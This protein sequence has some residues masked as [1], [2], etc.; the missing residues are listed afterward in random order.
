MYLFDLF[1]NIFKK[2]NFGVLI[3]LIINTVLVTFCFAVIIDIATGSV[4]EDWLEYLLGFAAYLLTV[5]VALSPIGEAILRFQTG[6]KKIKDE[7]TLE[8]LEKLFGEVREKSAYIDST[9]NRNIKMFICDDEYPNAFATGR[10]TVCVTAGLLKLTDDEIKGVLA[11]EFG[12]LSHKDTDVILVIAVGNMFVTLAV[13]T[14]G[15]IVR[16]F[17]WIIGLFISMISSSESSGFFIGFLTSKF[18]RLVSLL[19]GAI[20]WLWTKLGVVICMTSSRQNEYYAD[21]FAFETGF[22]EE[23]K[24][25][26][27]NLE[28]GDIKINRKQT[29]W[30]SLNASHPDTCLR[31]EKLESYTAGGCNALERKL[32]GFSKKEEKPTSEAKS[33]ANSSATGLRSFCV[34]ISE[35][36]F[37]KTTYIPRSTYEETRIENT[38]H[39]SSPESVEKENLSMKFHKAN[40]FFLIPVLIISSITDLATR[41]FSIAEYGL[42]VLSILGV[43]FSAAQILVS[44]NTLVDFKNRKVSAFYSLI[45]SRII[46]VLTTCLSLPELYNGLLYEGFDVG[47]TVVVCMLTFAATAGFAV[48]V[49]VYYSKRK[50][51]LF[52]SAT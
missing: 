29:L 34:G 37:F 2:K 40:I 48:I 13:S 1:A 39:Y 36:D 9:L 44:V 25:A 12:H 6:C 11:H 16:A 22:G 19:F 43:G 24:S 7:A 42:D 3:W 35:E 47:F 52:D 26:L 23:L 14:I 4:L 18:N 49:G 50:A 33:T 15:L 28:N 10:K 38:E 45:I 51:V 20:L 46:A 21:R 17:N 27:I 41:G 8:R 5:M 31:I 30:A 32:Q